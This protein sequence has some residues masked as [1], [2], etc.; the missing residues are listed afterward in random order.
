MD[1]YIIYYKE[2]NGDIA[3]VWVYADSVEDAKRKAES[4]YWDIEYFIDVY[5]K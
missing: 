3:H 5:K 1:K 4:E 2:I